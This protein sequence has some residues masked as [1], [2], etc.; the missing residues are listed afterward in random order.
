M[1]D[2][3]ANQGKK[4]DNMDKGKHKEKE[5]PGDVMCVAKHCRVSYL[6]PCV[7]QPKAFDS[8]WASMFMRSQCSTGT[9]MTATYVVDPLPSQ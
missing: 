1:G 6:S 9:E 7:Q 8:L 2:S 3:Y 5:K 4:G